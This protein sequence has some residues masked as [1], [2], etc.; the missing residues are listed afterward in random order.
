[1]K[2][3]IYNLVPK[4]RKKYSKRVVNSALG[5]GRNSS[6]LPVKKKRSAKFSLVKVHAFTNRRTLAEFSHKKIC[7]EGRTRVP[8]ASHCVVCAQ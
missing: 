7:N 3:A 4:L 8:D 2:H 1:M 6:F 5:I